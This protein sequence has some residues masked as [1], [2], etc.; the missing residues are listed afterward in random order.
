MKRLQIAVIGAGHLGR[1]HARLLR[2]IDLVELAGVVDPIAESRD[3]VADDCQTKAYATHHEV[4]KHIDAAIVATPTT[5]HHQVSVE[6]LRAGVHLLIEKPI[7]ATVAEANELVDAAAK[8]G[9]VLQVGHVER[10]NPAFTAV[11]PLVARPKFIDA[12]RCGPYSFRSTD[13]GAVLDLMIHDLDLVLALAQ[14]DVIDVRAL[15]VSVFGEREDMAQARVEFRNGCVANLSASRASL[16]A[17]RSMHV[18]SER[19]YAG[20]DFASRTAHIVR[21][22]EQLLRR[23]IDFSS[24]SRDDQQR[25]KENMFSDFLSL[26]SIEVE[27]RNAIL[28]EQRE[29]VASILHGTPPRVDG[30][31]ARAVLFVAEEILNKIAKHH[32]DGDE[33]GPVGPLREMPPTVLPGP[34]WPHAAKI[35]RDASRKAG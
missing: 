35:I 8:A 7:A 4:L 6:L 14:S 29:F 10:F 1:I 28:D 22:T 34:H 2:S 31:Q 27:E 30:H 32:W 5:L 17:E 24:I 33:D 16:K 23:E 12:T 25:I 18:Y 26:E 13:I 21:P 3:K 19:A 15:G 20:I 11:Q 9:V